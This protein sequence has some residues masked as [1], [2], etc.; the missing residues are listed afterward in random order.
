LDLHFEQMS[1][2]YPGAPLPVFK[3]FNQ[4]IAFGEHVGIVGPTGCGKSSLAYLCLR[5][6]DPTQ[7]CITLGDVPLGALSEHDLRKT[8][9]M[10]TQE[11]QLF[12]NSIR[13]HLAL[14]RPGLTETECWQAM[15]WVGLEKDVR[16]LPEQ[17]ETWIGEQGVKLSGGQQKRLAIAMGL[18]YAPPILILDEPTEGLDRATAEYIMKTIVQL[19]QG[20]TLLVISHQPQDLGVLGRVMHFPL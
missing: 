16:A 15:E 6:L 12:Q 18:L 5:F 14:A 2:C 13:H 4:T 7:G 8:I 9:S 10:V 3:N 20:K 1:F 11:P 17:L 19:Y